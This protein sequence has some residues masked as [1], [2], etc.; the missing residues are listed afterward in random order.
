M[1]LNSLLPDHQL[2]YQVS[3][4]S[5]L[6][7]SMCDTVQSMKGRS[8]AATGQKIHKTNAGVQIHD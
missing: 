8:N 6:H 1:H 7:S 4:H 3:P 2:E 5:C